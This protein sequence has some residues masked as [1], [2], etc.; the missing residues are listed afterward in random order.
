MGIFDNATSVIIDNK[1]VQSIKLSSNNAVLYEKPSPSQKIAT[2]ITKSGNYLYLYDSSNNPISGAS[3]Q[4]WRNN[5][6]QNTYTTNSSGR[7]TYN[8]KYNYIYEG[9]SAYEGCT[10]P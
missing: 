4:G 2:H 9:D 1:E 8:N 7:F 5:K 3:V 10:Y 6:L